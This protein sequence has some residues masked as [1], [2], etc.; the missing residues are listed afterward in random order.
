MCAA[1]ASAWGRAGKRVASYKPLALAEGSVGADARLLAM[2]T[3]QNQ[4]S[5]EGEV[6]RG[7]LD[8]ELADAVSARVQELAKDAQVV[9]V[10]GLPLTDSGG[11]LL[12]A[13]V[14]LAERLGGK[15]IG[16]VPYVSGLGED[17]ATLWRDSFGDALAGLLVNRCTLYAAHDVQGHL[18]LAFQEAGIRLLG[19]VPEE[20]LMLAPTVRQVAEHLHAEFFAWASEDQ[21]LVEQFII[22]G[23]ILEWGGN[24]FG[25]FPHQA[26]IVRGGRT[27]IAMAALNFPMSCLILTGCTQPSQYVYQR[28]NAQEV[29]LMV[30]AQDT[31]AV[32]QALE[33]LHEQVSVHHPGKVERFAELLDQHLDWD[34][35]NA[36][37]LA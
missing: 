4:Q 15:V 37:A 26:V 9:L 19:A 7:A 13:S 20:R 31:L 10:E 2:V 18:L 16:V 8:A 23:L 21:R 27:D 6:L 25:R 14:A 33:T 29:P 11:N 5:V 12:P 24:Y 3:G 17:A 28:A 32:A 1:L 35:A 34:A 30:V 36:A 22:G